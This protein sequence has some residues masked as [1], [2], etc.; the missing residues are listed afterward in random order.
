MRPPPD[1]RPATPH[2]AGATTG[3]FLTDFGLAKCAATGSKLT[4]TGQALGTPAY[5][6][7][8]QARGEPFGSARGGLSS[9]TPASDVWSLGC[10]L[11]EMLAGR[12]PFEGESPAAVIAQALVARPAPIRRFRPEVPRGIALLI[13]AALAKDPRSRYADAGALQEDLVRV[14]RGDRPRAR[15]PDRRR[16][17]A[18]A[19]LLLAAAG[20]G[21]LALGRPAPVGSGDPV[22]ETALPEA[23]RLAAR[24]R[25]L[26]VADVTE[27]AGL[28]R[29]A[30]SL[31][32]E[33]SAWRL[34][35]GLVLW[36]LGNWQAAREEWAR[37]G[38]GSPEEPA[39]LLYRG[40]EGLFRSRDAQRPDPGVVPDLEAA[41]SGGGR[42]GR[43]AR[44]AVAAVGQRWLEARDQLRGEPGWEAALLRGYVESVDPRGD[45]TAAIREYREA[46]ERGIAFAWAF[47]NCAAARQESGDFAGMLADSEAALRIRP[48]LPEALF[49]RGVARQCLGDLPR[50]LEDY[51]AVLRFRPEHTGALLNR[52][53][54]RLRLGDARAA[55]E[56]FDAAL[57]IRP[58]LVDALINRGIA[59]RGL[60]DPGGSFEDYD[61][62]LRLRPDDAS[63]WVGRGNAR[64]DLGDLAGAV[65][66]YGAA[67][68]ARPDTP[69]ALNNRAATRAELGDFAGAV[70]DFDA[71][72]R[73]HP[74]Y[75]DA[76]ANRAIALRRMGDLPAAASAYRDFLRRAPGDPRAEE[77]RRQLAECEERSRGPEAAAKR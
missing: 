66:D 40:L 63:A 8:A 38:A 33:R 73:L 22:P 56:D 10:V 70:A 25:M 72:L 39:A 68:R 58:D 20:T 6:S 65:E 16:R 35:H 47:S 50:A 75:T 5:M 26:R 74:D 2:P 76:L 21:G 29:R 60:R 9:L 41:A 49:N 46:L 52:G 19:A 64:R 15:R 59:K 32:P 67:L 43:L 44:A 55:V 18:L 42:E 57:R 37:V 11:H 1:P 77:F 53:L 71:V 7:P 13:R 62:A 45:D 36:A 14:L 3:T 51:G 30:L 4:R 61:A 69:E 23:E 34:E 24:A 12:P 27:A 48:E 17:L 54:A 31:E 28:L